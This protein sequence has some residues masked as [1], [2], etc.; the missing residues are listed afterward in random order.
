[1]KLLLKEFHPSKLEVKENNAYEY[2]LTK[3]L[4]YLEKVDKEILQNLMKE[5]QEKPQL[6][7]R[8]V[9]AFENSIKKVYIGSNSA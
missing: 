8:I 1:M 9:E 4:E 6:D 5:V 2:M 7:L 3:S